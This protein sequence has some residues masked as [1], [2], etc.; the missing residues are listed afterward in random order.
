MKKGEALKFTHEFKNAMDAYMARHPQIRN[1]MAIFENVAGS[2]D[3]LLSSLTVQTTAAA[4]I[5]ER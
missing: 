5:M 2:G 3:G 4:N 1:E